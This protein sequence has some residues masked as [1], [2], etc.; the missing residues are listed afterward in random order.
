[1]YDKRRYRIVDLKYFVEAIPMSEDGTISQKKITK[2]LEMC[3][4]KNRE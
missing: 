3:R 1:M 2:L 4:V